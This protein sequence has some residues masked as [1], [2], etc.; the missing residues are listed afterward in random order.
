M[1]RP[2]VVIVAAIFFA[3]ASP[4]FAAVTLLEPTSTEARLGSPFVLRVSDLGALQT[5]AGEKPLGLFLDDVWIDDV[6]AQVVVS[7]GIPSS[8]LRF[9]L[10]RTSRNRTAWA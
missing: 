7:W 4:A 10:V 5:Q 2:A 3:L 6:P 9:D 8:E 1:P